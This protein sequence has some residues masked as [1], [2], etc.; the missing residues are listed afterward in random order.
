MSKF[1][2][3]LILTVG[4]LSGCKEVKETKYDDSDQLKERYEVTETED[5]SFLKDGFYKS[6][7]RNGQ[8]RVDCGYKM[9][10]YHGEYKSY[11]EDGALEAAGFYSEGNTQGEW[12]NWHSNGQEGSIMQYDSAGKRHGEHIHYHDN[13]KLRE[14]RT[15]IHGLLD[16]PWVEYDEN[17]KLVSSRSFKDGKDHS[18]VGKWKLNDGSTMEFGADMTF[19]MFSVRRGRTYS[20]QYSLETE[21]LSLESGSRGFQYKIL[22]F[23]DGEFTIYEPFGAVYKGKRV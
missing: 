17:S 12:R 6:W 2:P 3:I 16:G 19:S 20:G 22:R 21:W 11:Y 8:V 5:G 7:Y 9:N 14:K 4:L 13:G 18:L 15:Y 1:H 23:V 10:E